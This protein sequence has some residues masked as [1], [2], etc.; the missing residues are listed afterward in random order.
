MYRWAAEQQQETKTQQITAPQNNNKEEKEEY[1]TDPRDGQSY[2][3]ME[4]GGLKWLA[5]NF[6]YDGGEGCFIHADDDREDETCGR[7]Y[8]WAAAHAVCPEGWR[9]PTREDWKTLFEI[10]GGCEYYDDKEHKDWITIG[11][12]KKAFDY[13]L[14]DGDSHFEIPL[15]GD[16]DTEEKIWDSYDEWACFW[17]AT[18]HGNETAWYAG[19][20]SK[21]CSTQIAT[22]K[23]SAAFSV[24]YVK[25]I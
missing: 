13:L 3:V 24:R 11:D 7:L 5:D 23:K 4:I 9:L 20:N 25:D 12:P 2:F 10:A 19:L 22:W 16:Y 21:E 6:N 18:N 1:F 15:A 17:T 14:E 8:T